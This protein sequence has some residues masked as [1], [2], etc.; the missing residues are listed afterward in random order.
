M[1]VYTPTSCAIG[2]YESSSRALGDVRD[3]RSSR[4]ALMAMVRRPMPPH[5]IRESL[6]IGARVS[7]SGAMRRHGR[8]L[9]A[10]LLT[11]VAG[12]C[13]R[14]RGAPGYAGV[15]E[16]IGDTALRFPDGS[17]YVSGFHGVA[18]IGSIAGERK[19]PF[20]II[21]GHEC[22]NCD[23]PPSVLVR[24]P[25]DG[26]VRD[27][28]GLP[29][30]HPYPGRVIAYNEDSVVVSHSRLFW[31]HCLPERPKGLIEYRTDFARNG[32]EPER[33]VNI[34]EIDGDS[35]VEWRRVATTRLLA[36]TLVQVQAKECAEIPQRDIPAPP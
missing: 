11:A 34:T 15:P 27:F 18:Y 30:W 13:D 3:A 10:L 20:I 19:A 4:T 31:G 17:V 6:P 24:S 36:T 33:A 1:V 14:F 22:A 25:S 7:R 35:L 21:A 5:G 12:G 16:A 28:T 32:G 29:G 23:A 2:S 8:I 9:F 26:P